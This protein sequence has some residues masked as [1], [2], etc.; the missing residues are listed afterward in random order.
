MEKV[1]LHSEKEYTDYCVENTIGNISRK[2]S[3]QSCF[4][5]GYFDNCDFSYKL[6]NETLCVKEKPVRYPRVFIWHCV[7]GDHDYYYGYF[8]YIEDFL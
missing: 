4:I 1:L 2:Y 8:I 7:E 6:D 5:D 3:S